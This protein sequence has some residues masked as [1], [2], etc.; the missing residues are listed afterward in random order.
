M[1]NLIY[2]NNFSKTYIHSLFWLFV[3]NK[4]TGS[5]AIKK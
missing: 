1:Y 3:D 4:E 5:K 2:L